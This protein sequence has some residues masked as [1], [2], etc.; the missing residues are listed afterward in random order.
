MENSPVKKEQPEL[1]QRAR[2]AQKGDEGAAAALIEALQDRVYRFCFYLTGNSEAA[3]DH[4]QETL[5]K[6][7][8]KIKTLKDP[9]QILSWTLRIAKNQFLDQR[10]SMAHKT[11]VPLTLLAEPTSP[12]APSREQGLQIQQAIACLEPEERI[13]I[14]LVDLEGYSYEEAAEIIN[15]SE[16]ALRSRL[17]RARKA[18]I[19]KYK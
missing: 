3:Q 10:K 19:E 1:A 18:F 5:L 8:E 13:V 17:H 2:D 12:V 16:D 14:L 11:S 4:C 6:V 7:L 15:V 9:D